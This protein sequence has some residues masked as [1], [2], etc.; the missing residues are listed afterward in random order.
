[1]VDR[2]Q[3]T[4]QGKRM[5]YRAAVERVYDHVQ[6]DRVAEAVML[7]L[8]IARHRSDFVYTAVFLRE[9]YR[10]PDEFTRVLYD[11]TCHLKVDAQAY[12][13]KLS[14]EMWFEMHTLDFS[15]AEGKEGE[16]RNVLDIPVGEIKPE[17]ERWQQAIKDL[18]VPS[19]MSAYDTAAFTDQHVRQKGLMRLRMKALQSINERVKARCLN[20]AI[21]VERQLQMEAK[22]ENFLAQVYTEVNNYFETRSEDLYLKLQKAAQLVDSRDPEDLCLLLTEVRRAIKAAADFLY[23][24][25]EGKVKC[26]DGTERELGDEQY[27]NRVN[28]YLMTAFAKSTSRDLVRAE[29]EQLSIFVRRLNDVAAK[30]VHADVSLREGKQGT[31]GLY[32]F[33]YNVV[34]HRQIE[35]P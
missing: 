30:G 27:L 29:F 26:A 31:I 9:L 10:S 7:C 12:L 11:D 1:M 3:T 4:T 15:L 16:T 19:G 2:S 24:P 22:A 14:L 34:T 17:L 35:S 21:R 28:E 23:P 32:M 20:F 25:K 8:R 18:D 33:L 13:A 6:N 5:D